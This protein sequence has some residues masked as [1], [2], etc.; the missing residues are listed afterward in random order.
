MLPQSQ[1]RPLYPSAAIPI[2]LWCLVHFV[3]SNVSDI[4]SSRMQVTNWFRIAVPI[5]YLNWA[6]IFLGA[7]STATR[8]CLVNISPSMILHVGRVWHL[9]STLACVSAMNRPQV[10]GN[11]DSH[12]V[13]SSQSPSSPSLYMMLRMCRDVRLGEAIIEQ[14]KDTIKHGE[15]LG[16]EVQSIRVRIRIS[17]VV[18]ATPIST[19]S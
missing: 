6:V 10:L 14:D 7:D 16:A 1:R 15:A 5:G 17:T 12:T 4:K 8:A 13:T 3:E 18:S 19:A 11:S 9:P 2:P